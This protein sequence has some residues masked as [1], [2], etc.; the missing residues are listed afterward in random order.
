MQELAL[1]VLHEL[2]KKMARITPY[3]QTKFMLL[4][5]GHKCLAFSLT[6]QVSL[7][8]KSEF[9]REIK[10]IFKKKRRRRRRRK[11]VPTW[12]KEI[13]KNSTVWK[14]KKKKNKKKRRRGR[15]STVW[16]SSTMACMPISGRCIIFK[17][18]HAWRNAKDCI[19]CS[20]WIV[21]EDGQDNTLHANQVHASFLWPYMLGIFFDL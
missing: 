19:K 21:K 5:F 8:C 15:C 11:S 6:W 10:T 17:K 13:E 18:F 12:D 16:S 14:K 4:F 20:S 7:T 9:L 1:N 3:M 2:S